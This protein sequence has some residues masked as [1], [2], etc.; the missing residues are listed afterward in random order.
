MNDLEKMNLHAEFL[1]V[2]AHPTRLLI[3]AALAHGEKCVNELHELL[4]VRQPNVS[5][6]LAA[7]KETGF[8][9]CHKVGTRRCY[10]LA[11]SELIKNLL[12]LL[13]RH[14]PELGPKELELCRSRGKNMRGRKPGGKR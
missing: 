1:K 8:V 4:D 6:H 7:L 13:R 11:Q 9:V 3:L 14:Y 5:Q 2:M 10:H 12:A